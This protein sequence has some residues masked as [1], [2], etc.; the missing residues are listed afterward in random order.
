MLEEGVEKGKGNRVIGWASISWLARI[1]VGVG[2]RG[3]ER[4][5]GAV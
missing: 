2:E 3:D 1:D 4:G 5:G